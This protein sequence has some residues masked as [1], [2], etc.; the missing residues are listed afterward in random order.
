MLELVVFLGRSVVL[1]KRNAPLFILAFSVLY[2]PRVKK[3]S[4]F[5]M[6]LFFGFGLGIW[7][8]LHSSACLALPFSFYENIFTKTLKRMKMKPLKE[9]PT[10]RPPA[11]A[12]LLKGK[13]PLKGMEPD[14][15]SPDLK[16]ETL[17]TYMEDTLKKSVM[18]YVLSS[19]IGEIKVNNKGKQ[20]KRVI[21]NGKEYSY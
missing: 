6:I 4:F 12:P 19:K 11:P 15:G 3:R 14:D 5:L 2:P 9:C 20:L 17:Y 7:F 21:I 10:A 13:A 18:K 1:K 8:C 16:D